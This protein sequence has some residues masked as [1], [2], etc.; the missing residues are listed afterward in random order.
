MA[1]LPGDLPP[2]PPVDATGASILPPAEPFPPEAWA[3][4]GPAPGL[5]ALELPPAPEALQEALPAPPEQALG[6]G[7]APGLPGLE[8]PPPEAPPVGSP[9]APG[10]ASLADASALPFDQGGQAPAGWTGEELGIDAVSGGVPDAPPPAAPKPT[11]LP[12]PVTARANELATM[13]PEA[14]AAQEA[15][16]AYDAKA[17]ETRRR[18]ELNEK[19]VKDAQQNLVDRQTANAKTQEKAD[20]VVNRAKEL[21]ATKTDP[22][23]WW[24]SRSGGQKVAGFIGAALSGFVDPGGKNQTIALA[25]QAADQDLEAQVQD[26]QNQRFALGVEE[27]AV[28]QEFARHGDLYQ[29]KETVRLANYAQID[30]QLAAEQLKFDPAGSK[31]MAIAG[32]RRTVQKEIAV[33]KAKQLKEIHDRNMETME[34]E[35]KIRADEEARR[36]NR[37]SERNAAYATSAG[38]RTAT[39]GRDADMLKQGFLPDRKSPGGYRF[40]QATA[41]AVRKADPGAA[42]KGIELE[43]KKEELAQVQRGKVVKNGKG[44]PIGIATYGKDDAEKLTI[45]VGD[46]EVFRE[47]A[48]RLAELAQDNVIYGGIG[49]E[50]WP[51]EAKTEA[52]TIVSDLAVRLAKIRDPGSVAREGEV[53]VAKRDMPKLRSYLKDT[54][55]MTAYRALAANVDEAMKVAIKGRVEFPDPSADPVARHQARDSRSWPA[56]KLT[57][58]QKSGRA[59]PWLRLPWRSR[60]KTIAASL[61]KIGSATTHDSSRAAA[62]SLRLK[63]TMP[64]ERKSTHSTI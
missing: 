11:F 60:Q 50:R 23:R 52:D 28:A 30:S 1:G 64:C 33:A 47:R 27:N 17:N 62:P 35:R 7:P 15:S 14:Y 39:A 22:G 18:A 45:Q 38:V 36:H 10:F 29:A 63:T 59:Q 21:A 5:P 20:A 34:A 56:W 25:M 53:A 51:A 13:D 55:P 24:A 31:A 49:S 54:N 57:H 26:F 19:N 6:T 3:G 44:K 46:F 61:S 2:V 41:D 40:D 4:L 43:I 42:T 16:Q 37:Q 48:R 8:L 58:L 32:H 9:S 12:D